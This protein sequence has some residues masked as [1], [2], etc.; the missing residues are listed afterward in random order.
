[1]DNTNT[2]RGGLSEADDAPALSAPATANWT[3]NLWWIAHDGRT[4]T[5]LMVHLGTTRHDFNVV[6]QT[7]VLMLPDGRVGIDV[8]V[9]GIR[10]PNQVRG[11]TLAMECIEP[12]RRWRVSS[13]GVTQFASLEDLW[14]NSP[15]QSAREPLRFALDATCVGPVW[16]AGAGHDAQPMQQQQWAKSHYQQTI[17]LAGAIELDGRRIDFDGTGVRDHS[18]GPR[19]FGTWYGHA[20]CSAPFPSG[21][22]FGLFSVFGAEGTVALRAA[23]VVRDGILRR[24][25]PRATPSLTREFLSRNESFTLELEVDGRVETLKVRTHG[26]GLLSMLAPYDVTPGIYRDKPGGIALAEGLASFEWDG[27]TSYGIVERSAPADVLPRG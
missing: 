24:G 14:Q 13:N 9:G 19:D 12:F 20:L 22:S 17:R 1:M 16:D 26:G 21:R 8:S 27:E 25:V 2:F 3:E 10:A 15:R 23:Y 18:R 11:A 7:V 4:H 5:G 6:R